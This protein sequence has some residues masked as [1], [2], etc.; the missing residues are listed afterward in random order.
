[1]ESSNEASYAELKGLIQQEGLLNKQPIYYTKKI[2]LIVA[3]LAASLA[4]FVIVPH[5]WVQ[6][7]NAAFLAFVFGQVGLIMHDAD[8]LQIFNSARKNRLCGL[9]AGNFI[10]GMSSGRW[11]TDHNIHHG[12]PNKLGID[13]GIEVSVLAFCKEQALKKRGI[14]RFVVKY[15]AYFL[16]PLLALYGFK[17]RIQDV[18]L[19]CM[20]L[21]GG[22]RYRIKIKNPRGE[23]F[24]TVAG[25][26]IFFGLVF[27]LFDAWQAILFVLVN[28]GLAGLYLGSIFATNHKGMPL[29]DERMDFLQI[30]VLTARNVKSNRLINLWMGGLNYQIEHH[31]FP[32]MPRNNLPKA[33]EIVRAYCAKYGM[34]YYYETGFFRSYKEIFEH[35]HEVGAVLRKPVVSFP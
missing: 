19:I 5:I 24:L 32:T 22:G 2:A 31:L 17:A 1:M 6:I 8:H 15:Q 18:V 11:T 35:L 14:A 20:S 16:I 13:P 34:S 7:L 28:H 29:F 30:Q 27:S 25:S 23:I 33:R 9:I 21:L 26:L 10:L 12:S 3:M 4:I